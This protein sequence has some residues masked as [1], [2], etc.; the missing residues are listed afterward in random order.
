MW[1][2]QADGYRLPTEAEWEYAARGE[3]AWLYSGGDRVSEVAWHTRNSAGATRMVAL[4][5]SN[6]FG[7]YDMSGNVF[8]Q[9]KKISFLLEYH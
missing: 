3:D 9:Q 8:D 6:G 7:L 5:R 1:K 4:K 2:R